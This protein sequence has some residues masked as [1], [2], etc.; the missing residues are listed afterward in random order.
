MYVYDV[1]VCV[2]LVLGVARWAI[3]RVVLNFKQRNVFQFYNDEK[4]SNI[5]K[6]IK[7]IVT[8]ITI[9]KTRYRRESFTSVENT[10][11]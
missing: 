2:S 3:L 7:K 11:L 9:L 8:K 4:Y 5:L 10:F 1:C 6:N